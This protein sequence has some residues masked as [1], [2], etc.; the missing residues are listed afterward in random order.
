MKQKE[1][2]I[3]IHDIERVLGLLP[4]DTLSQNLKDSLQMSIGLVVLAIERGDNE[5]L[6]IYKEQCQSDPTVK[7]VKA[8]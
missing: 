8:S 6:R 7:P 3:S 4:R 5:M 1:I 2:A